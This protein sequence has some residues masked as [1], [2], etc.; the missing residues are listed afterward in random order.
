MWL[1]PRPGRLSEMALETSKFIQGLYE[2]NGA[3]LGRTVPLTPPVKYT[4]PFDK[5]AQLIYLR[6]GNSTGELVYLAILKGK[7]PFR[8]FPL[9]AKG[10]IHVP[11]A[12]V[13]DIE[14]ESDL[15]LAVGAPE[16]LE[17]VIMVDLGLLEI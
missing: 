11:L 12:I 13:E 6:A 16:G 4:V 1:K 5:R 8:L 14:P 3:G 17:G 9:G 15:E 10:A 7:R 2:L